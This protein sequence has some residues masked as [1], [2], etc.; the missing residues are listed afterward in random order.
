[1][2]FR[3]HHG[4]RM[5]H[6]LLYLQPLICV[7][8]QVLRGGDPFCGDF[9]DDSNDKVRESIAKFHKKPSIEVGPEWSLAATCW[10]RLD[11]DPRRPPITQILASLEG[12][13]VRGDGN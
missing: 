2:G 3:S 13:A 11:Q 9:D 8:A 12:L 10:Y 1:M 4:E 5:Y 6:P 7:V